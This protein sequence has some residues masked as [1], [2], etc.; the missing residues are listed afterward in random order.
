[1]K[2]LAMD[3]D[4]TAV[5]RQGHL[6]EKTKAALTRARSLGHRVVFATGRR[7]I[8]MFSFWPESA[9]ADYL[10]LNNGGKLIRTS[11]KAVLFNE[12][13]PPEAARTLILH[14]LEAHWQLHVIS[15]DYWGV[16]RW[17]AGLQEYI[18]Y[19]GTSP[20]CYHRLTQTPWQSVEGFMATADRARICEWITQQA[21]PLSFTPS[22]DTCTDIMAQNISKWN[23][24]RRLMALLGISAEQ[25]IAAGDYTNDLPM[26]Q[27]AGIGVA[28]ANALPEV[29]AAADFVTE[30]DCDHDAAAE[31]IERFLLGGEKH[32]TGI[33]Y[34]N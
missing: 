16:N 22:E 3:L 2:L 13:I 31:I 1:M 7:D 11:D 4:G 23:G 14:C 29:K 12:T 9:F 34:G 6:G 26:I 15:A 32:G 28:V 17:N 33:F 20:V 27:S 8:D 24:L 19:L 25:V 30:Q 5:N 18:D 10:L 21:L